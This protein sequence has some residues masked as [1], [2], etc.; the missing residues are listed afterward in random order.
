[1]HLRT[2]I[3]T[4]YHKHMSGLTTHTHTHTDAGI[5]SL[6]W[7]SDQNQTIPFCSQRFPA[8]WHSLASAPNFS[9]YCLSSFLLILS[10]QNNTLRLLV[11]CKAHIT[12]E[13]MKSTLILDYFTSFY[14]SFRFICLVRLKINTVETA[15]L[16]ALVALQVSS[17][18]ILLLFLTQYRCMKSGSCMQCIFHSPHLG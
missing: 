7:F 17:R 8:V 1:M 11:K 2:N 13:Q 3:F 18:G 14:I 4:Y 5:W 9:V 16:S 10:L 12:T 6:L 15:V